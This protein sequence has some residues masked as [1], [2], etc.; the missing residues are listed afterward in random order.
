[1][2][3]VEMLDTILTGTEILCRMAPKERLQKAVML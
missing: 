2:I 1:M 3:I